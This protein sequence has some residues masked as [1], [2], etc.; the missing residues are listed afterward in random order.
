[1]PKAPPERGT[2]LPRI[3][4]MRKTKVVLAAELAALYGV[5]TK[6]LN[7]VVKRNASRFPGD[8]SFV[9]TIEEVAIL[10]SQIATSRWQPPDLSTGT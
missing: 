7:E 5:S 9:P 8:F 6:R 2:A 10:R 1:M 3:Y 4:T